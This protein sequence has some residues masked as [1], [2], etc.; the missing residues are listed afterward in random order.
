MQM[1]S[2]SN[3]GAGRRTCEVVEGLVETDHFEGG[4]NEKRVVDDGMETAR[5]RFE[6]QAQ[7]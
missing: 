6:V 4:A 1:L 5:Y 3:S 7:A 2:D